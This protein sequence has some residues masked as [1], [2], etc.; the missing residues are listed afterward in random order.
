M[1]YEALDN[2]VAI[3]D[4]I[5]AGGEESESLG[6]LTDEMAKGLKDADHP[7]AAAHEVQRLRGAP[8]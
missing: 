7:T 4:Q 8:A 3:A 2:I 6:R 5:R 1:S